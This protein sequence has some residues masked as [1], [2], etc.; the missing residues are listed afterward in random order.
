MASS[1]NQG[2][3][4]GLII[5]VIL[6]IALGVTTY[7][8]YSQAAGATASLDARTK[9]LSERDATLTTQ[10]TELND[11]KKIAGFPETDG[12]DK[13]KVDFAKTIEPELAGRQPDAVTLLMLFQELQNTKT[14]QV[15][16]YN[17]LETENNLLKVTNEQREA[18]KQAQIDE[19]TK[20]RDDAIAEAKAATEK[21]NT[22]QAASAK[23]EADLKTQI[24]TTQAEAEKVKSEAAAKVSELESQLQQAFAKIAAQTE[25]IAR[26]KNDDF[27]IP[28]GQIARV[29]QRTQTV[30]I[31]LGEDDNLRRQVVLAVYPT[32]ENA[33]GS[34]LERKATIEVTNILGPHL[35]EA[36]IRD[37]DIVNPIIRGDKVHTAM[38]APGEVIHVALAGLMDI[39]GDDSSDIELLRQLITSGGA[40]IDAE[41]DG[42]GNVQGAITPQTSYLITGKEPPQREGNE[43]AMEPYTKIR[44]D[45]ITYGLKSLTL[46][47]FLKRSGWKDIKQV[48]NF[49]R[50]GTA[51]EF[52]QDAREGGRPV[53]NGRTSELFRQRRPTQRNEKPEEAPKP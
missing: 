50:P 15:Q 3:Q 43:A 30:W 9:E 53:S 28:Y 52:M 25:E 24:E 47:E 31:N 14:E 6:V 17:E 37:D 18:A 20:A 45:A 12:I 46:T 11:L 5:S 38:W 32:D 21:F 34:N 1:E 16:R 48:M 51:N 7:L 49:T 19:I 4:A 44:R 13:I 10:Q 42:K 33:V 23:T 22:T 29:D 36:R 39:D 41:V 26:L 2:L 35:A 27:E 40:V 8:F